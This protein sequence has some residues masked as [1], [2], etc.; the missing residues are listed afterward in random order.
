MK[1]KL[2]QFDIKNIKSDSVVAAFGKRNTGKSFLV[3]DVLYNN[4]DIP[5]GTFISPTEIA[6]KYYSSFVPKQFIHYE[7]TPDLIANVI[8]RQKIIIKQMEK[9]KKQKGYSN[10]DP[11][12][13]LL[14]DDCLFDNCWTKDPNIRFCLMN[15]RHLKI[16]FIMTS[17]YPLGIPPILRTQ[18][19]FT[20]ILRETIVGNRKR[21]Y[22]NFAG[23]FPSQQIFDTV[24]DACTENFECLVIDNTTRSNKLEDQVFWFK[25]ES[26]PNFKL[27][28]SQFWLG[29]GDDTDSD[30]SDEE[31]NLNKFKKKS[32]ITL[33]VK[34]NY[35]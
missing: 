22:D 17:Q 13:I 1:L 11:R 26:R 27:G 18:I 30:D 33:N 20:F 12:I 28:A 32:S 7:Y 10:I 9:E 25:A 3:R 15:G 31:F 4:R 16:F 29:N 6:N 23:M 19:D 5:L 8:K 35:N 34:K 2:K 24:M 14:L 21:L